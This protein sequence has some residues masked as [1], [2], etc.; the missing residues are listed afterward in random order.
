MYEILA[1]LFENCHQA[2]LTHNRQEVAKRLSAA[3]FDKSD[4]SDA[5]GW[6]AG[7]IQA[8]QRDVAPL[9]DAQRS[10]RVYA[11]KELAKLSAGCRGLL[12]SF[13]QA[14][15]LTPT[16]RELAIERALAASDEP[17]SVEQFRL[18]VLMVLWNQRA[19][20]S[21]LLA[22]D[23]LGNAHARKPN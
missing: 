22:A 1:Y 20:V 23:L 11:P 3:G 19:P 2:D 14:G 7:V 18:I 5:L 10:F 12:L 13:E 21:R 17:L 15:I 6:M 4:I 8:P 16:M 9:P